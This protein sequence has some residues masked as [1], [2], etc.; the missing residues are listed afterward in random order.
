MRLL[1]VLLLA[2]PAWADRC[3][4]PTAVEEPVRNLPSESRARHAAIGEA[5]KSNPD[6]FTLNRMFLEGQVYERRT[7]RE[8]Y[9]HEF[10]MH[11]DSLDSAYLY[12][13]SLVGSNT[14]EAL[15]IYAQILAK[16]PDYPWVHLSQLEIYRAEAF[17]D[18]RKLAASYMIVRQVCPT[19]WKPF[20][21]LSEIEDTDFVAREAAQLRRLLAASK[22]PHSLRLYRVLWAA[23]F[24]VRPKEEH[25]AER[26]IVA[27]DLNRLRP[28]ESLPEIQTVIANGARLIGD[29]ALAKEMA[30]KR[31]PDQFAEYFAWQN[32]HPYPKPDDPPDKKRSYAQAQLEAAKKWIE[33]NPQQPLGYDERLHALVALEAPAADLG[34][35]ADDLLA[36]DRRR[37]YVLHTYFLSVARAYLDRS[38]LL[39]RV[40]ALID[41]A[42]TSFDDPESVIEIDLAPSPQQTAANR[43]L[44]IA[45]HAEAAALLSEFY[46]RQGHADKARDVLRS[47]AD[48]L[49][50]KAPPQDGNGDR[51]QRIVMHYHNAQFAY[52]F[53]LATLDDHEGRKLDA[54]SAYR[55]AL[56]SSNVKRETILAAQRRLWKELGGSDE[57]WAQWLNA[58]PEPG[59]L[60][61]AHAGPEF[62]AVNRPLPEFSLQDVAG[63]TWT[64]A[65]F[66]GKT[67]I[68]VV[69]A[70]WCAPCVQELPYF[71]KLAEKLKDRDDVEVVSFNTDQNIGAVKA[72]LKENG[73]IFPVLLAPRFAEDLMPYFSI[74]RTWIIRNGALTAECVG[75]DGDREKWPEAVIAQ[76]K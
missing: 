60:R 48:Y 5:L 18:R 67:T 38:V 22:E 14:R 35:T 52:W 4:V 17:R 10:E 71:A 63:N 68:A 41:E 43:M 57:A 64:L 19:E 47:L 29:D 24:R 61:T 34:R 7:V 28:F 65:R 75:F 8:R 76:L 39:D 13:R 74:P 9:Q 49:A 66:K 69:W 11:P 1:C 42:L 25:D 70:T 46:E 50:A 59:Q 53:R 15:K 3:T 31:P 12:G 30:A 36:A 27:E 55:E 16:D 54:L 51:E 32:A 26:R 73:Y 21:Y 23:E 72:F 44:A 20:E 62:I 58:A 40:P 33:M 6:D 2:A 37:D 45:Y 56:P